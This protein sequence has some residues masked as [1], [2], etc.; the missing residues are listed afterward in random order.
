MMPPRLTIYHQNISAWMMRTCAAGAA[1]TIDRYGY[2]RCD[3]AAVLCACCDSTITEGYGLD[4]DSVVKT[5]TI[6][7][8]CL[9]KGD[10]ACL[11]RR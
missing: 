8:G 11:I 7:A 3:P 4:S 10:E 2:C 9:A 5:L 6:C 1:T